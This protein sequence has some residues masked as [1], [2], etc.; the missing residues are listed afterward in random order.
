MRLTERLRDP[1]ADR[2]REAVECGRVGVGNAVVCLAE[3]DRLTPRLCPPAVP[4]VWQAL[5]DL[6]ARFGPR[7]I[8]AVRP[9]L[10]AD[11]GADGELQADQDAAARRVALSQPYDQG[12]GTFQYALRLDVEGKTVL[13]AALGP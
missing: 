5:I 13:E 1:K 11:Y 10:L 3:M 2:L 8:R 12:D 7:E 9:R 6:A 4:T